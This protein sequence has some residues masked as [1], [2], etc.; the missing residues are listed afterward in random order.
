MR[1]RESLGHDDRAWNLAWN[2]SRSLVATCSSDK[3][4]RLYSYRRSPSA[5]SNNA[6]KEEEP[7]SLEFRT[8]TVIPTGHS[9]T[10][11]GIAWSPSGKSLATASFD[12]TVAI[13]ERSEDDEDY[14]TI[15]SL[16]GGGEWECVSTLEGHE[17]ECK[18]V[19][20]S[21]SGTLLASSSRDK[22]VWIWEGKLCNKLPSLSL[23]KLLIR[24]LSSRSSSVQ[25][26]ADFECMSV[27]MEHTQDV[28]CVTWHPKE[29]VNFLSFPKKDPNFFVEK[30]FFFFKK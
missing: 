29:E 17:S 28:K 22:S 4:V 30:S 7:S 24:L 20:Y 3:S 23:S 11:R 5:V 26:D 12:S 15:G 1:I 13:F 25:P 18:S 21:Y 19:G 10:V 8:A 9:K 27:L 16:G 14:S 6:A 2:P